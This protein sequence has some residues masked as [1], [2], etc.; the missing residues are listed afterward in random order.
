MLLTF[1]KSLP[2]P[3]DICYLPNT[4]SSATL[5]PKAVSIIALNFVFVKLKLYSSGKSPVN[6]I[7]KPQCLT[8]R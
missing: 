5:P 2:H 1:D 4:I 6:L 7:K 3:D 8:N